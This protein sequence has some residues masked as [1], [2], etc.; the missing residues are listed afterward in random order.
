MQG[1]IGLDRHYQERNIAIRLEY[2]WTDMIE[3]QR[4]ESLVSPG[5]VLVQIAAYRNRLHE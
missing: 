1:Y 4:A 2:Q 3:A 5:T